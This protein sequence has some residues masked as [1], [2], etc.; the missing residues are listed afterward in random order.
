MEIENSTAKIGGNR[1]KKKLGEI[2][3]RWGSNL[4]RKGNKI[5]ISNPKAK[6]LNPYTLIIHYTINNIDKYQIIIQGDYK[7]KYKELEDKVPS[8]PEKELFGI[9]AR[10][11]D[12]W[13]KRD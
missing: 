8:I 6:L 1:F 5:I 13:F 11:K 7:D 10:N 4:E 2:F 9:I 12:K 3:S